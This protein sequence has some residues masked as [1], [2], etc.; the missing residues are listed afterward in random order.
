MHIQHGVEG[1]EDLL[2]A[3]RI[4]EQRRNREDHRQHKHPAAARIPALR[5]QRTHLK[6]EK[7]TEKKDSR[8]GNPENERPVAVNPDCEQ[9]RQPEEPAGIASASE[10][11]QQEVGDQLRPNRKADGGK[12]PNGHGPHE[13][14]FSISRVKRT[15]TIPG[16]E[17]SSG[18]EA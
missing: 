17:K 16:D 5:Y 15:K 13:S 12:E 7:G 10:A 9:Y 2:D 18:E 4:E 1:V 8:Q 6:A 3:D 14:H 11:D